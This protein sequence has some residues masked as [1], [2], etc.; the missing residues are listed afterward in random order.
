MKT[1]RAVEVEKGEVLI[2]EDYIVHGYCPSERW[3][4]KN[5]TYYPFDYQ[6]WGIQKRCSIYEVDAMTQADFEAFAKDAHSR[7]LWEPEKEEG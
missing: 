1:D 5:L 3:L 2:S 6:G 4:A 7:L